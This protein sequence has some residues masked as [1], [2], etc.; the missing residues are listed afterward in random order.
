MLCK[1]LL[2]PYEVVQ[3]E[4]AVCAGFNATV[5]ARHQAILAC[6]GAVEGSR[7]TAKV[8]DYDLTL[9]LRDEDIRNDFRFRRSR[10]STSIK[11]RVSALFPFR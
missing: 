4:H 2:K 11:R 5:D 9:E 6:Q 1:P 7:I 8:L 10:R 3:A